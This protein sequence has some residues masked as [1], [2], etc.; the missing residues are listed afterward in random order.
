MPFVNVTSRPAV[1]C[2]AIRKLH[3]N[4]AVPTHLDKWFV[5]R[6]SVALPKPAIGDIFRLLLGRKLSC[7]LAFYDCIV[8][9]GVAF[10]SRC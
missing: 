2:D 8:G 5:V 10:D 4:R 1:A 3:N 6:K 9:P 7:Q